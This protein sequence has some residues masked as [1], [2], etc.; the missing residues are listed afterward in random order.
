MLLATYLYSIPDKQAGKPPPIR[1]ENYEKASLREQ[2][3]V[4]SKDVSI[5]IPKTP[6]KIEEAVTTSRPGSPNHKFKRKTDG[7]SGGY[8]AKHA[9]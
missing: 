5:L 9:E 1:I 4:E 6:L 3:F 7:S 8:F 2:D